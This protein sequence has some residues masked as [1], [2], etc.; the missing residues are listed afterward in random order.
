V[1][2][3]LLTGSQVFAGATDNEVACVDLITAIQPFSQ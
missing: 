2:Y 1:L 3:Q